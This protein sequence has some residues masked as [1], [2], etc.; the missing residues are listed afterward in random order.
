MGKSVD[1][2]SGSLVG[3]VA[4][5]TGCTRGFGRVLVTDLARAGARVVVSSPWRDENDALAAELTAQS[6][7]AVS[8]LGDVTSRDQLSAL[9]RKAVDTFGQLDIWVNNAAYETPGMNR[10]L[11]FG[12]EI[13]DAVE[14]VNVRGTYN[15]TTAA[16]RVMIEQG[17][18]TI[19]NITGR[20]DDLRP[21]LYTVPYGAS[22]AWIR[23]FTRSMR[24]EYKNT[25]VNIVCFNPGVMTTE[26]MD[27][28]EA[29]QL[30]GIDP[31]TE[32]I[33]PTIMR[34]L[35]DPPEVA[36]GRLVEFLAAGSAAKNGEFRLINLR[37]VFK[38]I[39]GE[40]VY[41]VRNRTSRSSTSAG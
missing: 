20:G 9:A 23:S 15:G 14:E 6:W 21:T 30:A 24:A 7:E 8:A 18:G 27:R 29:E 37:K 12:D 39:G 19:I 34:V 31:R 28:A 11:D 4:V 35:G 2:T 36:S 25:G 38:G 3:K 5:V 22:K 10:A 32:K 1:R 40:A 16:L 17:G 26:R 41:Q 13:F 33:Y